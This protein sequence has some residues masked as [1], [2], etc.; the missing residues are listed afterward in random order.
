M[1]HVFLG[2]AERSAKKLLTLEQPLTRW[3]L[4]VLQYWLERVKG[5]EP[6]S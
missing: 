4:P 1:H 3:A 5:I 2:I 6:S